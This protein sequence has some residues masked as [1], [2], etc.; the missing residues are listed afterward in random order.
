MKD[1]WN[2]LCSSQRC[3]NGVGKVIIPSTPNFELACIS[4]TIQEM[5]SLTSYQSSDPSQSCSEQEITSKIF[6]S[7]LYAKQNN[8]LPSINHLNWPVL[9]LDDRTEIT[10]V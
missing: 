9:K 2:N 3:H 5:I 10:I 1:H 6:I 4:P 7:S 8:L